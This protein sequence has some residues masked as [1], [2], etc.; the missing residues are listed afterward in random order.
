MSMCGGYIIQLEEPIHVFYNYLTLQRS[1]NLVSPAGQF[2]S[3]RFLAVRLP[4]RC[5]PQIK[6]GGS[7]S[8][9]HLAAC[10]THGDLFVEIST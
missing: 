4:K 2:T 8:L 5:M 7:I 1:A 6:R 3:L 9:H 10:K